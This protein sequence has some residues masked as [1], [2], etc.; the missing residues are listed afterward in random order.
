MK[1]IE[2]V[3]LPG[4]GK[5]TFRKECLSLL[6]AS[7]IRAY[8]TY[9]VRWKAMR[10][11]LQQESGLVWQIL[12]FAS[13]FWEYRVLSLIW[14]KFRCSY[15]LRF[16]SNHPDL[17]H[18]AIDCAEHTRPP[19][20]IPQSIVCSQSLIEWFFDMVGY[21]QAA[22]DILGDDEFFLQEE[23]PCQH[24][25]YLLAFYNGE[26]DVKRLEAYLAA[27]PVPDML[28][29]FFTAPEL[30]EQRMN[31]RKKGVASDILTP[32]SVQQRLAVLE[33]R[34]AVYRKIADYLEQKGVA[35]LRLDNRNRDTTFRELREGLAVFHSS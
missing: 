32:L 24:A 29:A 26:F 16:I 30:C 34:L 21:Y 28:I 1:H 31:S 4:S 7:D 20:W 35:V 3:G 17:S 14:E 8:N 9:A 5:T 12:K 13:V 23:G 25:Y 10:Q 27:V 18:N 33:E 11:I 15:I 6:N 22:Q 2:F 19:A